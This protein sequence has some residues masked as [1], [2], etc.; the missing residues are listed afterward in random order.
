MEVC[1]CGNGQIC[2]ANQ[3]TPPVR[4][5]CTPDRR[6]AAC[7]A[8]GEKPLHPRWRTIQTGLLGHHLRI[9]RQKN[10]L[11]QAQLAARIGCSTRAIKD[12]EAGRTRHPKRWMQAELSRLLGLTI[13][14]TTHH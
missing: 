9:W 2:G 3:H 1:T 14:E 13:G 7:L 6:C 5:T 4:C 8:W 11:S 12:L 10:S